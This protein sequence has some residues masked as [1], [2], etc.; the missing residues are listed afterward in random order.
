MQNDGRNP[1]LPIEKVRSWVIDVEEKLAS[2][3]LS[4]L[5][6]EE[7]QWRKPSIFRLPYFVRKM[8][9]EIFSPQVVALGPFHHHQ[10]HLRPLEP[11]KERALLHFLERTGKPLGEFL[12]AMEAAVVELQESYYGLDD[13]E[14]KDADNFIK[15]MITDGCFMLEVMRLGTEHGGD[16]APSDPFFGPHASQRKVPYIKRDMLIIE[17]QVPLLA[18]KKLVAVENDLSEKEAEMEITELFLRFFVPKI[19]GDQ[20]ARREFKLTVHGLHILDLYRRSKLF[21]PS[22]FSSRSSAK[23]PPS[24]PEKPPSFEFAIMRPA[25]DLHEAGVKFHCSP[26]HALTAVHFDRQRGLL[27]LPLLTVDDTTEFEFLNM[28]ALEHLHPDSGGEISSF[29]VFMDALVDSAKDVRLLHGHGIL[30]N[31]FGRD[32]DL[33]GLFNSMSKEVIM[34]QGGSLGY[35]QREAEIYCRRRWNNWRANFVHTYLTNPWT[36]F[37]FAAAAAVILLTA[38]GTVFSALQWKQS[39]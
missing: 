27:S 33:A 35:V 11:H 19:Y 10:H 13:Q 23:V 15:L 36:A 24:A 5:S 3:S 29:V 4:V 18:L 12:R 26:T 14:W 28:V 6:Q 1:S 31:G 7:V 22:K 37:S 9:S 17:N 34:D 30:F 32:K 38:A 8:K 20:E 39:L 16:Y 2:R 25:V 21:I